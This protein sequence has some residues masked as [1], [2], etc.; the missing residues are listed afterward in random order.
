MKTGILPDQVYAAFPEDMLTPVA[1]V[2]E[3]VK[4]LLEGHEVGQTV[5]CFREKYWARE[6]IEYCAPEMAAL[7]GVAADL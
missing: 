5:E 7:M 2:V 4:A 1:S 3:R 6:Q